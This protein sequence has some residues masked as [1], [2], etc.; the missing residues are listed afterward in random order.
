MSIVLD[1]MV[2][3]DVVVGDNRGQGCLL[4][5]S[6]NLFLEV[7]DHVLIGGST[8]NKKGPRRQ[9]GQHFKGLLYFL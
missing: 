7:A 9:L 4:V 3:A 8:G 1:E 2:R 6:V 5:E